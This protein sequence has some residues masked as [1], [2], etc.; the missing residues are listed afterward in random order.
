MIE[1]VNVGESWPGVS[2]ATIATGTK[3][4]FLTGHCPTDAAGNVVDGD[5][6]HQVRVT[7]ENIQLTLK[8]AGV[9]FESVAKFNVFLTEVNPE[10]LATFKKVR[11]SFVNLETPPAFTVIGVGELWDPSIKVE[12]DGIAIIDNK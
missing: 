11:N 5:F 6:E 8:A 3:T 9:G 7:F 10:I 1:A 4:L 12:I 2:L